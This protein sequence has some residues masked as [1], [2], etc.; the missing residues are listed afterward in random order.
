MDPNNL[1][2][3]Y[4]Y[5]ADW[6]FKQCTPVC[7]VADMHPDFMRKLDLARD[8]SRVPFVLNSAFRTEKYDKEHGRSGVGMHTKGR[9]VDVKTRNSSERAEIVLACLS[10]GLTV[11]IYPTFVHI[12]DR[13]EQIVFLGK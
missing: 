5:F 12:D 6:E 3:H 4:R 2:Y 11:G 8:R 7:D 13:S 9:A 10:V 1:F